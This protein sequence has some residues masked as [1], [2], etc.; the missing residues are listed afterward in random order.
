MGQWVKDPMLPRFSCSLD[1]IP[2]SKNFGMSQVQ[3]K[4]KRHDFSFHNWG[5]KNS[6]KL[7]NYL[8][9]YYLSTIRS[10]SSAYSY[11]NRKKT[12]QKPEKH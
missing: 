4:K 6:L 5:K 11:F 8:V 10:D 7:Q 1:L 2:R 3:S 9:K 12:V